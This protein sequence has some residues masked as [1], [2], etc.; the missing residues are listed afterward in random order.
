MVTLILNKIADYRRAAM[1][2][3][4]GVGYHA[5][6]VW[7]DHPERRVSW[8]KSLFAL[9]WLYLAGVVLPKMSILFL[10]LRV[11]IDRRTRN[12]CFV[13]TGLIVANWMAYLL[14][15]IFQCW[16]IS[17]QWDKTIKGGRCFNQEIWYKTSSVPNIATDVIILVLPIPLVWRL[18][19]SRVRKLGL[20]VI[21]LVG[22][23]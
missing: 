3:T 2:H 14:A 19:A 11:F 13:L 1:V 23:T 22:S 9:Q 10:Y 7:K 20:L 12:I 18:K 17:Y 4:A 8:A 5:E 6:T 21:F 15:S 16:P